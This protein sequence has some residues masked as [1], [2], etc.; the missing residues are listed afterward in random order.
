MALHRRRD[1]NGVN[2]AFLEHIVKDSEGFHVSADSRCGVFKMLLVEVAHRCYLY[3][4]NAAEP[5]K[6]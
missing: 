3:I 1:N 2:V 5:H 6:G 4:L